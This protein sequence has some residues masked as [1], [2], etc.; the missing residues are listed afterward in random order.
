M[1]DRRLDM[2]TIGKLIGFIPTR[3]AEFA[4][5][6][7]ERKLGLRFVA[8]DQFALVFD[9]A[10]SMIRVVRVGEFTPPPFTIL[11]WESADIDEDVRNFNERGVQFERYGFPG[12]DER[13]IWTSP[14]GAKV[15]WFKDPDGNVL[16]LSQ[17][18]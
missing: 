9:S 17:H 16:S 12:Q 15:A 3:N 18:T 7:Y 6:F 13:G 4:R 11:G 2:A 1:R 14:S 10:G 5:D 8:D